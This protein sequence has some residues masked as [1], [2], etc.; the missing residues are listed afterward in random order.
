MRGLLAISL[1]T[2]LQT[3]IL[4]AA[5]LGQAERVEQWDAAVDNAAAGVNRL[6]PLLNRA[7]RTHQF[8][9]SAGLRTHL[10]AA[11][12]REQARTEVVRKLCFQALERLEEQGIPVIVLRGFAAAETVYPGPELRHCHDLDLFVDAANIRAAVVALQGPF[13]RDT[14]LPGTVLR[15]SSG[16]PLCL[17]T[18]L[19][20]VTAFNESIPRPFEHTL[21]EKMLTPPAQLLHTLGHAVAVGSRS[22]SWVPDAW[23]LMNRHEV[24]WTW[25][26]D[27]A[28][29]GK[30]A[31]PV[32][33][34]L[35][36]MARSFGGVPARVLPSLAAKASPL[37]AF[38]VLLSRFA[39]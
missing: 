14:S 4:R 1:P 17:H 8:P 38:R 19:F 15:H 27:R 3:S 5:L 36:F 25:V 30:M 21:P 31:G 12:L 7:V 2:A 34:M 11:S 10:K 23:F 18:R 16:F 22:P 24:D 37:D 28:A 33:V 26:A 20:R 39:G 35:E 13:V 32:S 6:L 9:I 29:R